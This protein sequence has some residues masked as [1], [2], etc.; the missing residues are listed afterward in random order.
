VARML[1][2][3]S[4]LTIAVDDTLFKR[5]GKRVFGPGFR[6]SIVLKVPESGV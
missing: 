1:P 3:D 4:A 2:A 6:S 5:S